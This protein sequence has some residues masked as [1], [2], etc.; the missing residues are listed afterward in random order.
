MEP[1][2]GTASLTVSCLSGTDVKYAPKT[3]FSL[4]F[5]DA[6]IICIHRIRCMTKNSEGIL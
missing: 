5:I 1:V 4:C 3:I 6:Q 2:L